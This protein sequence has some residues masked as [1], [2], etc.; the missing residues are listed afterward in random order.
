M[1]NI[2]VLDCTLRDGGYY[3]NWDFSEDLVQSYISAIS[4]ANI[5]TI[6]IG[7]RFINKLGYYGPYAYSTD[8]FIS[9]LNIPPHIQIGVMLNFSDILQS[10]MTV[11]ETIDSIF[12]KK[13]ESPVSLVRIAV[14]VEDILKVKETAKYLQSLGYTVALNIMQAHK[15]SKQEFEFFAKELTLWKSIDILYFA[16]TLGNMQSE[17]INNIIS[18]LQK[19]WKKPLGLHAHDNMG[20][21]EHNALS[22]IKAGATWIDSTIMGMGR[23]AGNLKTENLLLRLQH[24]NI[25]DYKAEALFNLSVTHFKELKNIYNWGENVF[26]YLSAMYNIHPS[27]V[28]EMQKNINYS[29]HDKIGVLNYLR[30]NNGESFS[31]KSLQTANNSTSML[32]SGD[33]NCTNWTE[34]KDILILADSPSLQKYSQA[35]SSYIKRK[36]PIV[37]SLNYIHKIDQ[38]LIDVYSSCYLT[39]IISQ[40]NYLTKINKPLLIPMNALPNNIKNKLTN[41]TIYN[42]GMFVEEDRL[43]S[44]KTQCILPYP[45]VFAYVLSTLLETK[46]KNIYLA[47]FDGYPSDDY[48]NDEIKKV[49][50]LFQQNNTN[51]SLIA[52]TPTIYNVEKNSIYNP[53]I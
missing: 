38:S 24:I 4:N 10:N 27:Y 31:K 6:E 28:Q 20:E 43:I 13:S 3:T 51:S 46:S 22:A 35:I 16:D 21:S 23:G 26:Y 25:G 5:G 9:Q 12:V 37:I 7:F 17:D 32:S 52:L 41:H 19:F 1:A 29:T 33:W 53:S 8:E 40:I 34:G 45:L 11:K 36:K 44:E 2:T 49:I 39:K 42:Y 18:A 47:G 14:H 15:C 50:E 30:F 48:R